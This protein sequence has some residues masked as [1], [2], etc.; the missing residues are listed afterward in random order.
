MA[1]YLGVDGGQSSTTALIGDE[2]GRVA[3]VGRGGPCNH[4][5]GTEARAKFLD[6]VGGCIRD[7][8]EQAGIEAARFESAVLGFSGGPADKEALVHELISAKHLLVT[9]DALTAL[10]GA[11]AGEP[12]VVTIAGTGSI[13]F[14]RN[15]KGITARAGGWG[16]VFGD[17][18]GAF[19]IVR[20][21]VRAALRQDEGWGSAT[22]LRDALLEETGA[23]D[24]NDLMHRFYNPE[25]PRSRVATLSKIVDR[26]AIEGDTIA[27]GILR[28]AAVELSRIA[29]AVR[30]QL[31]HEGEVTKV[32]YAGGVFRSRILC[33]HFKELVEHEVGNVFGTP[34]Y[35]PAAGALIEAYRRAGRAIFPSGL[36]ESEK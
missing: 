26:E 33:S 16:Y 34:S 14:G 7:A 4:V 21:A 32:S 25:Y 8:C 15:A 22:S 27:Q 31:F 17:E 3:G 23:K 19:D 10:A 13:A 20:E 28:N 36:P 12:G 5:R 30:R 35:A 24:A 2:A 29:L 1:Y 18:G 11:C 6:A 9:H